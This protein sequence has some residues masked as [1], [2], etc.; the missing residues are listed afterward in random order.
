[1]DLSLYLFFFFPFSV[2]LS[3]KVFFSALLDFSAVTRDKKDI[4]AALAMRC[5]P[6]SSCFFFFF[7]NIL[8]PL[9]FFFNFSCRSISTNFFSFF[10]NMHVCCPRMSLFT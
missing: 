10:R 6:N 7:S 9:Y 5:N 1:M 4:E 3:G 2:E 8:I